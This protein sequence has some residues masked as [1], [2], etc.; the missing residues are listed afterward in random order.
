MEKGIRF[1]D[2]RQKRSLLDKDNPGYQPLFSKAGWRRDQRDREK[3]LKRSNWYKGKNREEPWEGLPKS[4]SEGRI[5]KKLKKRGIFQK[6]GG[7]NKMKTAATAQEAV[8]A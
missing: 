3:A 5:M 8:S 2:D 6:D 1:F 4:R 7:G